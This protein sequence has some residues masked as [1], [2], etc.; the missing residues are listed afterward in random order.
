MPVMPRTIPSIKQAIDDVFKFEANLAGLMV[1]V[2]AFPTDPIQAQSVL[3]NV[4]I[5]DLYGYVSE[6]TF[7]GIKEV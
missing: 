5:N 4:T 1:A 6:V 7:L 2:G 3:E